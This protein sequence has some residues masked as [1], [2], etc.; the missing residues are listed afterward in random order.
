[1]EFFNTT[2]GFWILVYLAVGCIIMKSVD[3]GDRNINI[4]AWI[5]GAGCWLPAVVV[6]FLYGL[7]GKRSE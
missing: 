2:Y 6:G 7:L 3:R 4:I 1:M 5:I